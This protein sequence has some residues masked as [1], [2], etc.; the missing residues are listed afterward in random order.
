MEAIV[1]NAQVRCSGKTTGLILKA[2]SEAILNPGRNVVAVPEKNIHQQFTH[3]HR[4]A[5]NLA[6]AMGL[7]HMD[8]CW[9]KSGEG[10]GQHLTFR[11]T[12]YGKIVYKNTVFEI[13]GYTDDGCPIL[14]KALK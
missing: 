1:K 10:I 2:M 14:G 4:Y 5:Q 11:S 8:I 9:N 13:D 7:T 3:M 6:E 12:Y